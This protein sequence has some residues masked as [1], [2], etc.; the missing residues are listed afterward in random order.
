M[1]II[2]DISDERLA[3][4]AA[5]IKPMVLIDGLPNTLDVEDYRDVSFIWEITNP[6]PVEGIEPFTSYR[7]LHTF[8]YHGFFKPSVEEALAFLPEGAEDQAVGFTLTGPETIEDLHREREA[9][10]AGFHV[11][12]VTL[13]RKIGA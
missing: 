13:W 7:S 10:H 5:Q 2:P 12:E 8:G 11:G 4:L 6:Q 9:M 3:Q 1:F